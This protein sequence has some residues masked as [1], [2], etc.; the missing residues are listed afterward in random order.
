V[1][2]FQEFVDTPVNGRPSLFRIDMHRIACPSDGDFSFPRFV[3]LLILSLWS[4]QTKVTGSVLNQDQ[5]KATFYNKGAYDP[6]REILRMRA[7]PAC[8]KPH[9]TKNRLK[10]V[11][12]NLPY[13]QRKKR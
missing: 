11:C 5:L 4:Y 3:G 6:Q 13:M 10:R 7:N 2:V 1:A 9:D 12:Q 8:A